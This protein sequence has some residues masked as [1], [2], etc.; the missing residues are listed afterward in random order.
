MKLFSIENPVWNAISR[1]GDMFILSFLW[2]IASLPIFTIG[3]STT[4]AYDCAFKIIR[5]RDTNIFKDFFNSFRSNLKQ[6][7]AL[8]LIMLPIGAVIAADLYF[9]AH[10]EG[11]VSFVINA[12]SLGIAALY[13]MT[14]LFVFPVQAIFENPVKKT[15]KTAF[16]MAIQNIGTSFLLLVVSVGLSYLCYMVPIAAYIYL[17]IGNGVLI[18]VFAVRFLVIFRKYNP[19]LNPDRPEECDAEPIKKT[20]RKERRSAERVKISKGNR[21]IK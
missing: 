2:L 17:L 1:I 8:F 10:N 21:V 20:E 4:A 6:A 19:A 9:W 18:M 13:L 5:A 16:F 15:L 7:T 14:L 3:A 12:L 11:E